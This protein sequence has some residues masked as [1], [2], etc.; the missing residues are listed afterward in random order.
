MTIDVACVQLQEILPLRE[1]YRR[2]LGCQVV[3]DSLPGR[4]FGDLFLI[5][6]TAESRATAS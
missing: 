5:R 2:E 1:L 6:V 4:G 3:H